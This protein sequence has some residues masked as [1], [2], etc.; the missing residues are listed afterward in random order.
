MTYRIS[1]YPNKNT[2]SVNDENIFSEEFVK[3]FISD[4]VPGVTSPKEQID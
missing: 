3:L 1:A 4:F 2:I